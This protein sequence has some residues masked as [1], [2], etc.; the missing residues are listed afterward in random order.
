MPWGA[1][2]WNTT[3]RFNAF[4]PKCTHSQRNTSSLLNRILNPRLR[5]AGH[6][7]QRPLFHSLCM[8]NKLAWR[9]WGIIP[10]VHA[11]LTAFCFFFRH[12][13][14]HV[15]PSAVSLW[16]VIQARKS[17]TAKQSNSKVHGPSDRS[18]YLLSLSKWDSL[19]GNRKPVL[20]FS[21]FLSRTDSHRFTET[22][23]FFFFSFFALSCTIWS[24]PFLQLSFQAVSRNDSPGTLFWG[25]TL[26]AWI[27]LAKGCLRSKASIKTQF[28]A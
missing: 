17:W 10:A 2:D 24:S 6:R 22:S 18:N 5:S 7:T 19:Q 13:K 15:T 16:T 27:F 1:G 23:F 28:P 20:F 9:Y 11:N 21:P 14:P 8:K 3:G 4:S 25:H 12:T 26:C